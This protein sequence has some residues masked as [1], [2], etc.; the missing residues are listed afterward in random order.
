[1]LK[2]LAAVVT[3]FMLASFS[4]LLTPT[5]ARAD[6]SYWTGYQTDCRFSSLDYTPWRVLITVRT[7]DNAAR[8]TQI[9]FGNGNDEPIKQL[10]FWERRVL[11]GTT[12]TYSNQTYTFTPAITSWSKPI[13]TTWIS[14]LGNRYAHIKL[15]DARNR[16]CTDNIEF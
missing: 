14:T 8:I 6:Y 15:T 1:M 10:Q 5:V 4:S 12:T 3:P 11:N 7:S 13:T 9:Q 2:K 16:V